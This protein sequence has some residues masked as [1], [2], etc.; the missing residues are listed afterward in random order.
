MSDTHAVGLV[1]AIL[2]ASGEPLEPD[3]IARAIGRPVAEAER[4]CGLLRERLQETDSG[5]TLLKL[6][7][8]YQLAT[9]PEYS[10]TITEA[11]NT[12]RN[13]PL[14][15]A[16]LEVLAII[17]YHQP[18]SKGYIEEV[19]GTDSS[20]TVNSLVAKG[21]VEEAGRLEVPGRPIVFRTT[22]AFLRSFS[23]SSLDELP[24]LESG[25]RAEPDQLTLQ[26]DAPDGEE[27]ATL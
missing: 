11:L 7:G 24:P 21:L 1:E 5:L 10:E 3:R 17:A 25:V 2:F 13:A 19:R 23:L 22:D 6:S 14:S 15:Q 27:Q 20:S 12:R 16:A 26:P 18:V 9:R 4:L 8:R